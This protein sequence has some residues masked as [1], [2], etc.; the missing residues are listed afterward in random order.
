[1]SWYTQA[2]ENTENGKTKEMFDWFH[3][4]TKEHIDRV[5]KY[6]KK[7]HDLE[8]DRFEG[9]IERGEEHD[10]SKYHEPEMD[11]YIYI[12][13]KYKCEDDGKDYEPPEDM[14]DKMNEATSHHVLSNRHHPEYHCDKKSDVINREDRDKPPEEIIDATK[15]K[16]LDISEM[17]C[18]WLAMAEEKGTSAKDW[19]DKNVNIR[20]KFTDDQKDLIYEL[21]EKFSGK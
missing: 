9:I 10:E 15:M 18:D 6:C 13:W 1:M 14:D 4:R 11:P 12:S 2:A 21:I 5:R 20:W 3:K 16:D 8:D 17:V 19:A 7:I